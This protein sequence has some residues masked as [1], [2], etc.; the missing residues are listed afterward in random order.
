MTD[1]RS[2]G[3]GDEAAGPVKVLTP[4]NW[5]AV[6][7]LAAFFLAG[8]SLLTLTVDYSSLLLEDP[9]LLMQDNLSRA[10]AK[11][12]PRQFG[13]ADFIILGGSNPIESIWHG[14]DMAAYLAENQKG[15]AKFL[16][17]A[18]SGQSFL[19]GLFLLDRGVI[20][21]G[22]TVI[23]QPHPRDFVKDHQQ[24]DR[25]TEGLF[26]GSPLPFAERYKDRIPILAHWVRPE[27]SRKIKLRVAREQISRSME[28][29]LKNWFKTRVY[30]EANWDGYPDRSHLE[31][32]SERLNFTRRMVRRNLDQALVNREANRQMLE[33][34]LDSI[35]S[36][37]GRVILL[38]APAA[39]WDRDNT[40]GEYWEW[41]IDTL[42]QTAGERQIP[43]V[44]LN[45]EVPLT[46]DDFA[47]VAH[48]HREARD[49]W[50]AAL[51][52]WLDDAGML[53]GGR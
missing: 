8:L 10:Y 26:L 51:I 25:L 16:K 39:R 33:V 4:R 47:E 44:D 6:I 21:A 40:Y 31:G 1:L 27:N 15:D 29:R 14:R 41:Y 23:L 37:G 11:S 43:L 52:R 3:V 30:G 9:W 28:L 5:L 48:L 12:D 18:T 53:G 49:R 35:L 36:S 13:K 22:Q 19:E 32:S 7:L 42:E 34:M 2:P 38:V 17:L 45:E 24:Y 50:S 20:R 46:D